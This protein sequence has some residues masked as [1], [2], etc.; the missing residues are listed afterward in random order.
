MPA[1]KRGSKLDKYVEGIFLGIVERSSEIYVGT[2]AGVVRGRSLR[3][4]PPSERSNKELLLAVRGTPWCAVPG[5]PSIDEVPVIVDAAPVVAEGDLL[6]GP[7][8]RVPEKKAVVH[9]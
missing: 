8:V 5:S 1:G 9:T 3:R 7:G 4:R 6:A 2:A